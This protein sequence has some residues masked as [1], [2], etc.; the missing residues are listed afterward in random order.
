MKKA[1]AHAYRQGLL[2]GLEQNIFCARHI[3]STY[4]WNLGI[5]QILMI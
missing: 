3:R 4:Y 1:T 2:L 5:Q